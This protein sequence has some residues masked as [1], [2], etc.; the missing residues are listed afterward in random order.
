[1]IATQNLVFQALYKYPVLLQ[2][3]SKVFS[4]Y[5]LTFLSV[6]LM[7]VTIFFARQFSQFFYWE[8]K[9]EKKNSK[10]VTQ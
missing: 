8:Q 6:Y 9:K 2:N 5:I 4:N 3:K 7:G 10:I 1:M